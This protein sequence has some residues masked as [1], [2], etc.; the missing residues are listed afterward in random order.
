[1]R[2]IF[3]LLCVILFASFIG[4]CSK[5]NDIPTEVSPKLDTS[6]TLISNTELVGKWNIL[7]DSLSFQGNNTMYHGTSADHYIFTKYG[8]M[9]VKE[10]F[11]GSVID[12]A[13]YGISSSNVLNWLNIYTN[14]NGVASTSPTNSPPFSIVLDADSLTLTSNVSTST[15]QRYEQIKFIK[16]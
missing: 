9:Y 10:N 13:I 8:N 3:I 6:S 5:G 2:Y 14:V 4:S 16:Q 7:T 12:T 15:G 1:M 11:G